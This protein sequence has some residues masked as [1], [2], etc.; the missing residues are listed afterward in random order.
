MWWWCSR[1]LPARRHG[2]VLPGVAFVWVVL[3][4]IAQLCIPRLKSALSGITSADCILPSITIA[5]L[6]LAR[7]TIARLPP[8]NPITGLTPTRLHISRQMSPEI[9]LA[10][11]AQFKSVV[12]RAPPNRISGV[13]LLRTCV[14]AR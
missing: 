8:W 11:P 9:V 10:L 5:S 2:S 13:R 7:V 14:V 1:L 6:T 4:C 3:A 12:T